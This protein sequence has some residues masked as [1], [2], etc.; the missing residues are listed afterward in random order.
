MSIPS[1]S[2][3]DYRNWKPLSLQETLVLL[4]EVGIPWAFAGGYSLELFVGKVY[5]PHGDIDILVQRKDQLRLQ[6][7][8]SNWELFRAA[9]EGLKYWEKDE[10]LETGIQDIWARPN[11]NSPWKLQIMLF[12]TEDDQWLYKRNTDI[13][14]NLDETFLESPAGVPYLAP[15]IQLLYKSIAVRQKDQLDFDQVLPELDNPAKQWL[16]RCLKKGYPQGHPW[17]GALS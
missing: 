4:R 15:E 11:K 12:D 6:T 13:R 5:R 8:L 17:I 1:F 9:F 3:E 7:H 2:E 14:R 16:L 10:Y